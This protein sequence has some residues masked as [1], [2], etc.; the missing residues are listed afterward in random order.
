MCGIIAY[1]RLQHAGECTADVILQ[2]LKILQNRGYD[3]AGICLISRNHFHVVKFASDDLAA[4][5]ISK[6]EAAMPT[7]TDRYLTGVGHTRW[8]THGSKIDLNSHPHL[9]MTDRF[10]LVHNGIIENSEELKQQYQLHTV[11][12]T[13]SEVIVQMLGMYVKRGMSPLKALQLTQQ[14]LEGTW[15]LVILDRQ[16]PDRLLAACNGSSLLIGIGANKDYFVAS[17]AAAFSRYTKTYVVLQHG[18]VIQ[19]LPGQPIPQDMPLLHHRGSVSELSP[20]PYPHWTLR[21][22]MEQPLTVQRALNFGARL[23]GDDTVKLGGLDKQLDLAQSHH[24]LIAACGSSLH[25][26]EY[27]SLVMQMLNCPST[28]QVVDAAEFQ[29]SRLSSDTLLLVMSQSGETKDVHHALLAAKERGVTCVSVVNVVG[30]LIARET[31]C[32]VYLNAGR[33]NAVAATKT[34][35]AQ[36]V[37]MVLLA[38]WFAQHQKRLPSLRQQC[39]QSV[40][41]LSTLTDH[42]LS[43]LQTRCQES[44]A[45][46]AQSNLCVVLGKG[47]ALPIAKEGA[48]KIMELAYIPSLAYSGGALKHGP[49]AVLNEQSCAVLLILNDQHREKMITCLRELQSRNIPCLVIGTW[50]QADI[51]FNVSST[52]LLSGSLLCLLPLQLLAYYTS[53]LLGHT[54]DTPKHICKVISTD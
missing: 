36:L 34:V 53:L 31:G 33:E 18:Q 21:E 35:M 4:N 39:I 9:D 17:E 51:Y 54:V 25:A 46:L 15:G 22:I 23:T 40:R 5:A 32:G 12:D 42:I 49:L 6:V 41:A 10:A 11:S 16:Q 20:A 7:A 48:L 2:G 30:S 47:L 29:P 1:L 8:A 52:D 43:Q 13:D 38:C 27:G 45:R 19:L 3:S 24:L 50:Q 14:Q 28:V 44:A 26:A 37:V